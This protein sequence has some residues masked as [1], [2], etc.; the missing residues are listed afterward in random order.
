MRLKEHVL[1]AGRRPTATRRWSTT[2]PCTS[3]SSAAGRPGVES[4][5]ALA[6]LSAAT[7]P[8]TTP[9]ADRA[10]AADPRR[11]RAERCSRC[12]SR[13]SRNSRAK[14][15]E[16]W[17]VEVLL[18]EVVDSGRADAGDP[19]VR[20]RARAHTLVWGAG[21]QAPPLAES[22]GV[23]L[24]RGNRIPVGPDFSS[25]ASGGVRDRRHRL[26]HGY[27]DRRRPAATRFRGHAGRRSTPGRTSPAAWPARRHR[28][29]SLPR[30]GHDGDD[31]PRRGGDQFPRG[32]TMKGAIA[33]LA[34]GAV[35]LASTCISA[36]I[37]ATSPAC[38]ATDSAC[39]GPGSE[40]D[41]AWWSTG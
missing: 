41:S 39:S 27:Q 21:S 34:W 1:A 38:P 11:G 14:L 17:G 16:G 28:A 5:G 18:G 3:S 7:S 19:E 20:A 35:H 9:D 37:C 13:S 33:F 31:R 26:D 23:E 32:R 2:A 36:S 4:V 15:L 8:R 10:G 24:E 12:S 30:Q 25:R 29:R 6:E 22:L 40:R